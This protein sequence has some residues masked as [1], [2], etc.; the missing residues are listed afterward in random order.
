MEDCSPWP[1]TG[2]CRNMA[3]LVQWQGKASVRGSELGMQFQMWVW[4][5]IQDLGDDRHSQFLVSSIQLL[6]TQFW[7][8]PYPC[9][10]IGKVKFQTMISR[11]WLALWLCKGTGCCCCSANWHLQDTAHMTPVLEIGPTPNMVW[12]KSNQ[13]LDNFGRM[14][15]CPFMSQKGYLD[16]STPSFDSF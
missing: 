4:V 2:G 5:K 9:V 11:W 1:T 16:G 10:L 7:P 3:T 14:V 15:H 12:K 8:V 13:G 6:G